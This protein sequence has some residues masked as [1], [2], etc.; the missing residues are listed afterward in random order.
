MSISWGCGEIC[1]DVTWAHVNAQLAAGAVPWSLMTLGGVAGACLF[2]RKIKEY[3]NRLSCYEYGLTS[4]S[5]LECGAIVSVGVIQCFAFAMR[6]S[7]RV[8]DPID[9]ALEMTGS[10][11]VIID[12]LS[13]WSY[14]VTHGV[15]AVLQ[16]SMGRGIIDSL[17]MTAVF[18]IGLPGGALGK[19]WFSFAFLAAFRIMRSMTFLMQ[20]DTGSAMSNWRTQITYQIVQFCLFVFGMAALTMMVEHLD[21]PRLDQFVARAPTDGSAYSWEL[22]DALS[23]VM[24]TMLLLGNN[25]LGP[26]SVVGR[27]VAMLIMIGA[28]YT[29]FKDAIPTLFNNLLGR[30][31]G[32]GSYTKS[33]R[34]RGG[35]VVVLGTANAH[36]LAD[37]FNEIYHM[38]HFET[39]LDF[40]KTAPDV[41][42][43]LPDE[44]TLQQTRRLL[45]QRSSILFRLRVTLIKGEPFLPRDLHRAGLASASR[46][47]VLP[48]LI[49][50]DVGRDDSRNIMRT[51]SVNNFAPKLDIVCM[52]HRAEHRQGQLVAEGSPVTFVSVDAHKL[53]LMAK[54]CLTRG[55][56]SMVCNLCKTLATSEAK[57]MKTWQRDYEHS[58]G[59]ELYEVK[60]SKAYHERTFCEVALDIISRSEEGEVYLI[61]V[62]EEPVTQYGRRQV[63]IH[64]GIDYVV[65]C[66]E[67][68]TAGIFLA[69]DK[70]SIQQLEPEPANEDDD[71]NNL[72]S[73]KP[74]KSP[75]QMA[76]ELRHAALAAAVPEPDRSAITLQQILDKLR[77]P[78]P[79]SKA[80]EEAKLATSKYNE[81]VTSIQRQLLAKGVNV[82]TV[83][84]VA[85]GK[86]AVPKVDDGSK[87]GTVKNGHGPPPPPTNPF[88][89][90]GTQD[91]SGKQGQLPPGP[92]AMAARTEMDFRAAELEAKHYIRDRMEELGVNPSPPPA[93]ALSDHIL[94]CIVSDSPCHGDHL[95]ALPDG[96]GPTVGIE[97]FMRPLRDKRLKGMKGSLGASFWPTVVV[98]CE[99]LPEDWYSVVEHERLYFVKGSPTHLPDLEKTGFRRANCIAI[100]RAHLG[101]HKGAHKVVD[102]RVLVL[103]AL[104]DSNIPSSAH[105]P[106]ITDLSFD[107]SCGFLPRSTV[108][109][110]APPTGPAACPPRSVTSLLRLFRLEDDTQ[111]SEF[112]DVHA[113]EDYEA[114]E[115]MEYV[116]HYRFMKGQ[117]FVSSSMTSFVANTFYNPSLVQL[118]QYLMQAP[119][120][121]LPLPA[122]WERKSYAD[123][124]MW[125]LKNRNLLALGLYRSAQAAE[126]GA[127]GQPLDDNVPTFH[128]MFTAP[129]AYKTLVVRSDRIL[130]LAPSA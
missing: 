62:V 117:V 77:G 22:H 29:I 41:V 119:L 123:L 43:M 24:S 91:E 90:E 12:V 25:R 20:A 93:S 85:T 3:R 98:I 42:V 33:S 94:L 11:V 104:I 1:A 115:T 50:T 120:L 9:H 76:E 128:Y 73:A 121:I 16:F 55:A 81:A 47:F 35:H 65:K 63:K 70:G 8:V 116:Y 60:L 19:T 17:C 79:P 96:L 5:S 129:A 7:R 46:A 61:G 49:C 102:A 30:N 110:P 68:K 27:G 69:P 32:L 18:A 125:L 59:M 26:R 92:P 122:A 40:D 88:L 74:P 84:E 39:V 89:P 21:E 37:F 66:R 108:P 112:N 87:N 23:F 75:R 130:C 15:Q 118:V 44:E 72:T 13:T 31:E 106:V 80:E 78:P 64:P 48:D 124:S 34:N 100:A 67:G 4:S 58:L 109:V 99:A 2:P 113:E 114:L 95:L 71:F 45:S 86:A 127:F 97:H 53:S 52:L 36:M 54:A 107:G 6:A 56:L 10:L 51:F 101:G 57:R 105:T 14:V 103:A 111:V 126:S 82:A 28:L 38:D 83:H